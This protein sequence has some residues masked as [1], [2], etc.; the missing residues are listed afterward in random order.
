MICHQLPPP[1]PP[2][3]LPENPP[4][5]EPPPPVPLPLGAENIA[6]ERFDVIDAIEYEKCEGDKSPESAW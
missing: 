5:P 6:D 2:N 4:P 3:P 1:P